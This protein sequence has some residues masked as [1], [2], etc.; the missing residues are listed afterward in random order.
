MDEI[1]DAIAA[2][3]QRVKSLIAADPDELRKRLHRHRQPAMNRMPRARCLAVRANDLRIEGT[4]V[5]RGGADA[6][7]HEVT[8]DSREIRRLCAPVEIDPPGESLQEVAAKLGV[9]RMG[10]LPARLRNVFQVRHVAGLGGYWGHPVPILYTEKK[11]DPNA[12]LFGLADPIWGWLSRDLH[13]RIPTDFQQTVVRVPCILPLA[14]RCAEDVLD[15]GD[16][17]SPRPRNAR[18]WKLPPP[19]PDPV[20]YKWKGDQFVGYDWRAAETNPLIRENYERHQ[21]ELARI[22]AGRRE[23]RRR[24][25]PP[26]TAGGSIPFRGWRWLC[27]ACQRPCR[28]LY[29]PLPPI[30]KL[31]CDLTYF[32]DDMPRWFVDEALAALEAQRNAPRRF[33]C[34]GCNRVSGYSG[35]A[36]RTW[37]DVVSYLSRGLLYGHE[38]AR[39][40][41]AVPKRRH[42]YVAKKRPAAARRAAVLEGILNGRT[43]G[44]IA[45]D[46]HVTVDSVKSCARHLCAEHGVHSRRELAA[47]LGVRPSSSPSSATAFSPPS[48]PASASARSSAS[49]ASPRGR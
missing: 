37:N 31:H 13:E 19:E 22:R 8:L 44:Q 43:S 36:P 42:A 40:A 47:K 10:L 1:D 30:S 21:R 3:W 23:K 38:V 17:R 20:W 6:R 29:Y 12:R 41:C 24:N 9:T 11:L 46:L 16:N 25:P 48:P 35:V 4:L 39:P 7:R 28:L 26:S 27:P 2:A 34:D 15:L 18:A 49:P 45:A 32:C 33:A 14:W 5:P